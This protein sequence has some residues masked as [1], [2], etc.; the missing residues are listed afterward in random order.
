[1]PI[2]AKTLLTTTLWTSCPSLDR[3]ED[4]SRG[5]ITKTLCIKGHRIP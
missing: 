2:L 1:V 5:M 4:V 3:V